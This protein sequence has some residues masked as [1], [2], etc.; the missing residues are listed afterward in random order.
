MNA[1]LV[2]GVDHTRVTGPRS[3]IAVLVRFL[4]LVCRLGGFLVL[5]GFKS[6]CTLIIKPYLIS[7]PSLGLWPSTRPRSAS[8]TG[9]H[10]SRGV[11]LSPRDLRV[12]KSI[13]NSVTTPVV[14]EMPGQSRSAMPMDAGVG[15]GHDALLL[16]SLR[17]LLQLLLFTFAGGGRRATM[18]AVGRERVGRG[19]GSTDRQDVCTAA[20][21]IASCAALFPALL[22][23]VTTFCSSGTPLSVDVGHA[24]FLGA[25]SESVSDASLQHEEDA[26]GAVVFGSKR[27]PPPRADPSSPLPLPPPCPV[28]PARIVSRPR[29]LAVLPVARGA[30]CFARFH[31]DLPP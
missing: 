31:S 28:S 17:L 5:N 12:L 25:E 2:S 15:L 7:A 16:S 14:A 30:A 4:S 24:R 27:P 11:H 6:N 13:P 19:A 26:K 21:V 1:A 20:L 3:S 10:L 22:P 8:L 18:R 9:V 23:R 29:F